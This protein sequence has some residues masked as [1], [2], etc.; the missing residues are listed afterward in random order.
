LY[1]AFLALFVGNVNVAAQEGRSIGEPGRG[2]GKNPLKNVY[3]GEQHLHTSA[4]PDAFA[5]G[6]RGTWDDAYRYGMGE[7]VNLSTTGEKI[8][9]RTPYDF[10][11][12]TDH[13]EYFGVM[14]RLVDPK[15]PLSKSDFAKKLQ[16]KN[17]KMTDPTSAVSIILHSILTST[18]MPEYVAPEMLSANW[19]KYVDAANK[20][21]NPGKFTT[22][23]AFEWTSIPNGRNMHRN[24]FFRNDTG[25]KVPFSA[26]DS[27]YPEDLLM[28]NVG[29]EL[30]QILF[31]SGILS[32]MAT[33]RWVRISWP[34]GTWRLAPYAIGSVSAFWT[35]QRV[36]SFF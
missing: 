18:A 31:L 30:G 10:I 9:K 13:A 11:A 3:F 1:A 29:V 24:V 17:A 6:T 28:F 16:D 27:I 22:L 23:I 20:H 25:P 14:P 2:S 32:V 34:A 4:S 15:D 26:F 5:V 8:K 35:I 36:A 7:E 21:N 12:I 33:L 19:K